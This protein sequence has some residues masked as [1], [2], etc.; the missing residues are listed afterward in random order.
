MID[1]VTFDLWNTL[2]SNIPQDAHKYRQR[3]VENLIG[4]LRQNGR[5]VDSGLLTEA[6]RKGFEKCTQIWDENLDLSTEEQ[7]RIMFGFLDDQGLQPCLQKLM[8]SLVEAYVSPLLEE[9]PVL[10]EG[11][12]EILAHAKSRGYKVGLICNTGTTPGRT[13]RLLLQRL[14]MIDLFDVTTFSNELGIRKPDPRI[15]LQALRQLKSSPGN[16][17]HVGD[18]IDVDVLGA[19]NVGMISVH[20]NPELI[21]CD[22]VG[23]DLAITR[24]MELRLLL[25]DLK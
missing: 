5:E 18:L 23:P 11:A 20:Y 1:T 19:K 13:I 10:I 24:L 17:A 7:L 16:S 3:R 4:V 6:Y 2:I 9:P 22:D 14:E 25:T 12:R 8:P 15:F 21:P